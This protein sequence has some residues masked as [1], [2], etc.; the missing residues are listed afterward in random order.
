MAAAARSVEDLRVVSESWKKQKEE[1]G[2]LRKDAENLE[3]LARLE[4]IIEAIVSIS[5]LAH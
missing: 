5:V 2:G 4:Q 3:E 1:L